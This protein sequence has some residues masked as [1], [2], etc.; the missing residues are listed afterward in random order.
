VKAKDIIGSHPGNIDAYIQESA[1]VKGSV[2]RL[3]YDVN[4]C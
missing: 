1:P 2:I 4:M 3:F